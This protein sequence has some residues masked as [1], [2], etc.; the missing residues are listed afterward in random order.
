[1]WVSA[2]E[3]IIRS[4]AHGSHF[5]LLIGTAT[6]VVC[7]CVVYAG[8]ILTVLVG[9]TV[10]QVARVVDAR[11]IEAAMLGW[12]SHIMARPVDAHPI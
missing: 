12:T 5:T 2:T 7:T 6:P 1:M 4:T 8:A 3:P 9:E 10:H 11:P